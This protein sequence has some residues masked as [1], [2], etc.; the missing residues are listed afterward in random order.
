MLTAEHREKIKYL[1]QYKYLNSEIDRKIKQLEDW[2]N[3]IYNVTGTL[4]DMPKNPNRSNTIENGIATIDEI[5]ENINID[6]DKLVALRSEIED[7]INAIEDLKLRE[8]LK[9]RYLDC[10]SWE[11]IAFR[12]GYTWRNAYYLHEKALDLIKIK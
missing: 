2:R 8:L 6:I 4:S 10:Q 9:C 11:E 3:K 1:N 7:K 5:E 12:N